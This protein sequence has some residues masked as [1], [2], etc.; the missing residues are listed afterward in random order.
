M[1]S[2]GKLPASVG[3]QGKWCFLEWVIQSASD[4]SVP[5]RYRC[6]FFFFFNKKAKPFAL[7][8]AGFLVWKW[9]GPAF[10]F[11]R[12]SSDGAQSDSFSDD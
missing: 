9:C 10:S 2:S 1:E 3:D 8:L 5:G 6:I 7:H 12:L 11:V 4:H